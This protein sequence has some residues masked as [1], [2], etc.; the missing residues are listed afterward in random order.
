MKSESG[1]GGL[2]LELDLEEEVVLG[3]VGEV[4][5]TAGGVVDIGTLFS[6]VGWSSEIL[7]APTYFKE[8]WLLD[9]HSC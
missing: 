4:S 1:V 8:L 2:G 7:K 6:E 3:F 5:R 9:F